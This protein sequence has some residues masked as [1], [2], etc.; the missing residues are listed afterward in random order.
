M[1]SYKVDNEMRRGVV[2]LYLGVF[3]L[4]VGT[5][6]QKAI[7]VYINSRYSEAYSG[8]RRPSSFG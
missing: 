3:S 8:F 4:I 6:V 5:G 7:S 1:L 2:C